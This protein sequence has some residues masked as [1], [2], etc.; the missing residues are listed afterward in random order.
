M[1]IYKAEVIFD[2]IST[3]FNDGD[4]LVMIQIDILPTSQSI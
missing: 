4:I 1:Y 3:F 2:L